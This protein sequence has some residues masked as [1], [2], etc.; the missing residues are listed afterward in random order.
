MI[1][2]TVINPSPKMKQKPK[3]HDNT[4]EIKQDKQ[5]QDKASYNRFPKIPNT[6]STWTKL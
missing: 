6:F 5:D 1:S 3:T 4:T 2:N